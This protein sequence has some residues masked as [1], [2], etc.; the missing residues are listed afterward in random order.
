MIDMKKNPACQKLAFPVPTSPMQL[1]MMLNGLNFEIATGMKMSRGPKCSTM[2]RKRIGLKG[3]PEKLL[4][5][6]CDLYVEIGGDPASV[7]RFRAEAEERA[8]SK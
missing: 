4:K 2:L 1:F 8:A 5:Q 7:E 3:N 6:G